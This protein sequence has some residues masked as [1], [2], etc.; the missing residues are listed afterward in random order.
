M[1]L[2]NCGRSRRETC[3]KNFGTGKEKR[4]LVSSFLTYSCCAEFMHGRC[5]DRLSAM[6]VVPP[7]SLSHTGEKRILLIDS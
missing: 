6:Q 7:V 5:F 2:R 1:R 3:R 4:D